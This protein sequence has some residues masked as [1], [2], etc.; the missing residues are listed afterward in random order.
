MKTIP[1]T[2][3]IPAE[4]QPQNEFTSVAVA[5]LQEPKFKLLDSAVF[6]PIEHGIAPNPAPT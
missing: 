6:P 3:D 2:F 4:K 1:V 5:G